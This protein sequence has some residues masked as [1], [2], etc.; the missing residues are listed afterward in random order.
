MHFTLEI[1]PWLAPGSLLLPGATASVQHCVAVTPPAQFQPLQR[2]G[3]TFNTSC[4]TSS[5]HFFLKF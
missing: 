2:K 1:L 4:S 3:G 5:Y